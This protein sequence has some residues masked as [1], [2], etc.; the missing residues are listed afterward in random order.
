MA[1]I[2][3]E[4]EEIPLVVGKDAAGKPQR[5][6]L[7][8]GSCEI[9]REYRSKEWEISEVTLSGPILHDIDVTLHHGHPLFAFVVESIA[10]AKG[11][12]IYDALSEADGPDPDHMRRLQRETIMGVA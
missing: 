3:F 2:N 10:Q 1:T 5:I 9:E 6:A 11:D 4:F 7:L 12:E 8:T